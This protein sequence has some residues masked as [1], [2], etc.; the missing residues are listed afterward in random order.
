MAK[1]GIIS[2]LVSLAVWLTGIIVSLAVGY[3]LVNEILTVPYIGVAN[4]VA[5]WVVIV[6]TL[7]SV[8][9]AII[10]KLR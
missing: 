1:G 10:D 9:L 2:T 7:V 3:G 8:I 6:L 4:V 5:G